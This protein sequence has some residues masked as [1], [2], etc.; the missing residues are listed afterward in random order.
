MPSLFDLR[1]AGASGLKGQARIIEVVRGLVDVWRGFPL[2]DAAAAYPVEAPRYAP[3]ADGEQAVSDTTLS[4]LHHWFRHE[5][6]II[7]ER[8]DRNEDEW[9][10]VR[11]AVNAI[12]RDEVPDPAGRVDEDG[13]PLMV[14]NPYNVVVSVMMLKEGWDVRN[15]KVIV[16]LRPCDPRT[17]TE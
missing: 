10:H 15:V 17:L 8:E 1:L 6:H 16:P 9:E 11:Q 12:D 5:P 3:A 4:L 7:G 14:P 2:G 13:R